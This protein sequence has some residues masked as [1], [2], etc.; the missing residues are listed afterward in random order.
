M[1]IKTFVS[2]QEKDTLEFYFSQKEEKFEILSLFVMGWIVSSP[3][4][5]TLIVFIYLFIWCFE[6]ES[7]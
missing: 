3:Q 4:Q 6:T 2:I 1:I 5:D 7:C